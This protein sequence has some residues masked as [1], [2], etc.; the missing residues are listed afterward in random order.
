MHT[1]PV[2]NEMEDRN[3]ISML[4]TVDCL[5]GE[6]KLLATF[7]HLIEAPN[8]TL[9]GQRL[10]YNSQGS[11]FS[12]DIASCESTLIDAGFAAHC[13]NDH[14]LSPDNSHI[15]VSHHTQEDGQSRIYV[16]PLSGGNPVLITPL[17]P[18]YLHGWSPDGK[19]LAY[20]AERNGQYDIY[21]L[22]AIG[23]VETQLTNLPGLD[24]GPEYTPDGRHI[25]FNSV[26]TGLMQVWRMNVDGSAQ[27]QMTFDE[28]NNWFPHISPDSQTVAYL[29]YREGDVA[30]GDH[31]P[32]KQVEIRLM[33]SEGGPSK[34]LVELFGGQGT[35]NVN[36]WSPDSRQLAF[37]SYRLKE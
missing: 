4:E 22:P 35:L 15:A 5:T 25:W 3:V 18:S 33:P 34:R 6:R 9:D 14:V 19:Q 20:C 27:T 16:F 12:F 1:L 2:P 23:G 30:P 17:A 37:V 8:W 13:N 10:I 26:R 7:D 28:S 31:P 24:D 36:S 32:N 29:S 11:L 21:T